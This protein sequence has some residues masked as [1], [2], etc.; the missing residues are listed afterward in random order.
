MVNLL[1]ASKESSGKTALCAG[2][3]KKLLDQGKKVGYFLPVRLSESSALN[4]YKDATF[5]KGVLGLEESP[6][7][8]SPVSLSSSELW[9]SLTETTQDFIQ[10]VKKNYARLSR[11][12]D[13][14]VIE[15]LSG[16]ATDNVAT[17]A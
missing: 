9:K 13:V 6:E 15:G 12:K 1:I 10:Q 5:M 11:G 3:G 17:L 2:I 7:V 8:L 14:V 16:L 4:D